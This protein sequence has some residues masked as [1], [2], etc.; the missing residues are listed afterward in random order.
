MS[1]FDSEYDDEPMSFLNETEDTQSDNPKQDHQ[2]WKILIVDDEKDIHKM[3][4]L[5]LNSVTFAD[6]PLEFLN[7]YS[8]KEAI[9]ILNR[10]DDIAVIILDVVMEGSESGLEVVEHIRKKLKNK[11]TRIILRTGQPG[12]APE[13][14]VIT[15]YDINDYKEKN[16]L[17]KQKLF[18]SLITAIRSYRDISSIEKS[19]EE[20]HKIVIAGAKIFQLQSMKD[21]CQ[22]VLQQLTYLL[23]IDNPAMHLQ[24]NGFAATY[25]ENDFVV[26][27]STGKFSSKYGAIGKNIIPKELIPEIQAVIE[28]EK[29]QYRNKWYIG[30]FKTNQKIINIVCIENNEPMDDL[31]LDLVKLFSMD[32]GVAFNNFYLNKEIIDTQKELIYSLGEIV[33]SRSKETSYHVH[34][35]SEY[36]QLICN[37]LDLNAEEIRILKIAA[38]MHDIGKLAIPDRILMKPSSLDSNEY[39][40]MQTHT[41]I[42]YEIL[43]ASDRPIFL[44]AAE[45]SLN[46]HERW[47]GKGYPSGLKGNDIPLSARITSIVDVFDALSMDRVYRKAWNEEKVFEYISDQSGKYFDPNIVDLF[48]S[49]RE[50]IIAIK[51]KYSEKEMI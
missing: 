35:V 51:K 23:N 12:S 31:A 1:I 10:Y 47:D 40:I 9:E 28:S 21:F 44:K 43:K 26:I 48:I 7:A 2:P 16:E 24:T 19:R 8:G 39:S 37:L 36:V 34:R 14:K 29:S 18:T 22:A 27:A 50:K 30:Y 17:T 15:E 3:T 49:N 38:I 33:E 4:Q 32:V 46:H 42:G 25:T 6:R 11:I 5:V 41:T 13:E 20:L 45:I